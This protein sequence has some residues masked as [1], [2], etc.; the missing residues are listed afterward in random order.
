MLMVNLTFPYLTLETDIA[1]LR[2]KQW[3]FKEYDG[4]IANLWIVAFY[5]HVFTSVFALLAGFTQFNRKLLHSKLHRKVGTM[6]II[7]VLLLSGP[8]GLIMGLLA[9]GGLFSIVA[10]TLLSVLWWYYTFMAYKTVKQK[11]Y[12]AHAKN[13]F[14]SYALTLSAITLRLWKFTIVNYIYEV[15]PM[16]L[17]RMV[18][19]LGWVPNLIIAEVMIRKGWHKR[20]LK[21]G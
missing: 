8:S 17:Y 18:A 20:L 10:F 3:V 9:N 1:F 2:I 7:V 14:R 21:K 12:E 15:P 16:D 11:N 6:Y 19:W 5:V 13:M 4:F